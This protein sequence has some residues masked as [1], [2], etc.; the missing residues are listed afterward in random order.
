MPSTDP[1]PPLA[2]ALRAFGDAVVATRDERADVRRGAVYDHFAGVGAVLL[3]R[4]ALHDRDV[5]RALYLDTADGADLTALVRRRFG[6]A[7]ILDTFGTGFAVLARSSVAA[8]EGTVW[9]G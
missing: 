5:F 3:V 2:D 6:I 7:R 4:E 9:T 1:I 8:G